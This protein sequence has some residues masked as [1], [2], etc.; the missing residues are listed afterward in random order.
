MHALAQDAVR[1][2]SLVKAEAVRLTQED[3][4]AGLGCRTAIRDLLRH[5]KY[6]ETRYQLHHGGRK[7]DH[8]ERSARYAHWLAGVTGANRRVC[9][10]AGLLHDLHSR[11]GTLSTHGAIAACVAAEMGED[12]DVCR[13]IL[14]HMYPLGPAPTTREGWVLVVAD[15]VATVVD[16]LRFVAWMLTGESLR[17]RRMLCES[18]PFLRRRDREPALATTS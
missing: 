9:A 6:L 2:T 12:A 15:K 16:T 7:S 10:R 11:L 18:D 17:R 1:T 13:A 4:D 8:L 14:P 3:S 5:P